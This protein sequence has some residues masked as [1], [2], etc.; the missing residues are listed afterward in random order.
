[1]R[2]IHSTGNLRDAIKTGNVEMVMRSL[3]TG[4]KVCEFRLQ[5]AIRTGNIEMIKLILATGITIDGFRLQDAIRTG[6]MEIV[7]LILATGIEVCEFRLRD[8]IQTGNMEIVKL[9]DHYILFKRIVP[10]IRRQ[11]MVH[12][13]VHSLAP[14]GSHPSFDKGCLPI[15]VARQIADFMSR[16]I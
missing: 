14:I 2:F 5:D 7:K 16:L 9:I 10:D 13:T 3:A 6:N 11:A 15:D 8:A 1:M 12:A 4:V